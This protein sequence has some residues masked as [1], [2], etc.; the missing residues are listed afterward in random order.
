MLVYYYIKTIVM[1]VGEDRCNPMVVLNILLLVPTRQIHLSASGD[2]HCPTV[3]SV[4]I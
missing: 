4:T 2:G 3:L 1:F